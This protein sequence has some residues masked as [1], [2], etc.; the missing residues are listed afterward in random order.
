MHL[1]QLKLA[2]FKSFVDPTTV[3]FLSQLI[4]VV[5][6]NGCGKSN[7]I[8]AIRWV[9]GES[10]AKNLRGESMVDVIF[11]GS[12]SRKSIGQA[13]VELIFDNS[14]G[15]LGGPYASYQE[16][17]VKR[18]VTREG[19]SFYFL[20]GS[21]C[22][23]RDITDIFLGTGA[24]PR[25]Y[26]IIGQ[27]TISRLVEARPEE[28]RVY[29]EEA[30]GV[31]KYKERRRETLQRI[32]HTRE[33]LARVADIRDELA[34]QLQ[35]LERQAT[36]AEKYTLLKQNERLYKTEILALKWQ[37]LTAEQV[38]VKREHSQLLLMRE[39]HQ[40]KI[41]HALKDDAVLKEHFY[42][43]QEDFQ[44]IQTQFY[45]LS[46]EIARLEESNQQQQR[47]KQ[48]IES[49]TQ[50]LE[51]ELV[52]VVQQ[53]QQNKENQIACSEQL[54]VLSA[55]LEA[56]QEQL[57]AHQGVLDEKESQKLG[58][59]Q[60]WQSVQTELHKAQREAQLA[61]VGLQHIEQKYQHTQVRFEKNQNE[62]LLINIDELQKEL[63]AQG[64]LRN[65]L[66]QE[67]KLAAE[68]YRQSV[69]KGMRLRDDLTIIEQQL[70]HA[71]EAVQS[72]A[73]DHAALQAAQNAVLRQNEPGKTHVSFWND[74]A[75]LAERI[76]VSQEWIQA[77][78][79]VLGES[80]HAIVLDS[81]ETLLPELASLQGCGVLFLQLAMASS[82]PADYPR[83]IDKIQG[84][85]P[86]SSHALDQVF[87]AE[88]LA[89]AISWLPSLNQQQSVVTQEG[90]WLG[91]GWVKINGLSL[92]DEA[93]VLSRQQAL[94][95]LN[96]DLIRVRENF[97][98][99]KSNREQQHQG[100]VENTHEQQILQQNMTMS[101]D[102][103]RTADTVWGTKEQALNHV[104]LRMDALN[105]E[106]DIMQLE[107]EEL[108]IQKISLDKQYQ[109]FIIAVMEYEAKAQQ[110][111]AAKISWED[112]LT[113]ARRIRDDLKEA[114]HQS[115]LDNHR[116]ALK[117]QQLQDN[118]H[119]E[120]RYIDSLNE[121]LSVLTQRSH[122][123]SDPDKAFAHLLE[124]KLQ[125]HEQLDKELN[126][127]RHLVEEVQ[128]QLS[129][130]EQ[131]QQKEERQSLHVL[132]KIQEA[133]LQEQAL[134]LRINSLLESLA[135]LSANAENVLAHLSPEISISTREHELKVLDEK[136]KRLG[137]IN[138]VAIEEYQTEL[139]RHQHLD[140][141][142]H[143][144]TDALN[145]LD[146]A[147]AKMDKETQLRLKDT[148][149]QVNQSFQ[150][151]F[152]RLF[153]GG[154]AK[155]E[156]TSENLLDAGV[157]VMAQ[158]PGKRNSSIHLLSGGEKAMTAVALVFAIFQLNPSPF[159]MLDEVDAPLD[160]LNVRRF[161]ELVKEMSQ[162]VQFLFITHNKVTME[163]ADHL[164]GVTMREPGV[165]RVVSVNV[166][167]ALQFCAEVS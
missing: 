68:Q 123:L 77:C 136:I 6:P 162:L 167:E 54:M 88:S 86:R 33:N 96:D 130:N 12:T 45:Q 44:Q 72:L 24:G 49:D 59:E 163:L 94:V 57:Q 154:H 110:L 66:D 19:D 134:E 34:K 105:D 63:I 43:T 25:S 106:K 158:P 5:G 1:K 76:T 127:Q 103:F 161:C 126:L 28:L 69:E 92:P 78:E 91:H 98:L 141:Q 39:E 60:Q 13:S 140:E 120:Q 14:L 139:T 125:L 16:I 18:L 36:A 147:I 111:S 7:I 124:E 48:R 83:L 90:Y 52:A 122:E 40:V 151:L 50:N 87:A 117:A 131:V 99:I 75:R 74:N 116:E 104:Q 26:S 149:D 156:L 73:T 114:L 146:A 9:M 152:P 132:E 8:D 32:A 84:S 62:R 20:N 128:R 64:E 157:Y 143:D 22:R 159:C 107:L 10:S 164:I 119:R 82:S 138:L 153:G 155:L 93:S 11:N 58:W 89:E 100:W 108:T 61:Q 56:L 150:A 144:L 17:S 109:A 31:S 4:A 35:R 101:R 38:Q 27:D 148:F 37:V 112:A 55:Q 142:Y 85:L 67:Q 115:E 133:Q 118:L 129:E 166:E 81:T 137:A 95:K 47:E 23:R 29:L 79:L 53:C 21:R 2:G 51:T 165:S 15:R 102:A 30:A 46:T 160:D 42:T 65:T 135:E 70:Q 71:Q 145:T 97:S 113:S 41:M 3:P 80:L 121:R